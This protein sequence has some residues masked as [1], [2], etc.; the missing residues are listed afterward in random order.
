MS[1]GFLTST[2][3]RQ[4]LLAGRTQSVVVLNGGSGT[5]HSAGPKISSAQCQMFKL[6]KRFLSIQARRTLEWCR[7]V[8]GWKNGLPDTA[9]RSSLS[10]SRW[11]ATRT[12][13][14][15][16]TTD[17]S[18]LNK[19]QC[20]QV[21]HALLFRAVAPPSRRSAPRSSSLFHLLPLWLSPSRYVAP[22][23]GPF[24]SKVTDLLFPARL[25]CACG[26]HNH[27]R[28]P[29]TRTSL[30]RMIRISS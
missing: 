2:R 19:L 28:A 25:T 11:R 10:L 16:A 6:F 15:T 7:R 29:V 14:Q 9:M 4:L 22:D 8:A 30:F 27:P 23:P 12:A 26:Q 1:D 17:C 3:E 18:S 13:P 21:L 5:S 24:Q 20:L